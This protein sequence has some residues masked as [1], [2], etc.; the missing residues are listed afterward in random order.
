VPRFA[1]HSRLKARPGKRDELLAKFLEIPKM[2]AD[3]P[4]CELT[5]V[6]SSPDEDDVVYLTEVWRSASDH[7]RARQSPEVQEWAGDMPS[8]VAGP[9]DTTPLIIEGGKGV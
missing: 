1:Q 4:A 3:N 6:S 9:P 5:I 2:Q 7:E 8:L